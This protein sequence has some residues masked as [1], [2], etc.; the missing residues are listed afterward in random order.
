[1]DWDRLIPLM[2]RY[3][4]RQCLLCPGEFLTFRQLAHRIPGS[5]ADVLH[6][7]AEDRQ[8]LFL[9]EHDDRHGLNRSLKL[10]EQT[11]SAILANGLEATADAVLP[12]PQARASRRGQSSTSLAD[13]LTAGLP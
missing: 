8:D 12:V 10:Y 4:L 9:L 5:D 6:S 1:M 13:T 7:I 2:I 3:M 11:V